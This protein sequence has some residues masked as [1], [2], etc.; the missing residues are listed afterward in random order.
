MAGEIVAIGQ[1]VKGWKIGDRVC[2]SFYADYVAG[3]ITPE[4]Q[5]SGYGGQIHGMLTQY[6]VVKPHVGIFS[7]SWGWYWR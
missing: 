5:C 2:A 3:D 6:K 7:F 4:I 1:D